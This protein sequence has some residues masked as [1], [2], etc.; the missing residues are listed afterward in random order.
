V[1][2][3]G[4]TLF[5]LTPELRWGTSLESV[6]K[7][8]SDG[9]GPALEVIGHQ[10]WRGFP[11]LSPEVER[12][13]RTQVDDL[14]LSLASLGVYTDL[15]REPGRAMSVDQAFDDLQPQLAAGRRLGFPLVRATLGMESALLRRAAAEAARLGIGLTFEVQ[16]PVSPDDPAVVEVL[17]LRESTDNPYLG[18][19]IDF[20]LTTP[21]LPASF[22]DALRRRGVPDEVIAAVHDIWA[23][24]A[25]MGPRMHAA[26]AAVQQLPQH[27]A[28][29]P[30]VGGM[31]VRTGRQ[32]PSAWVDVLPAV[33][34]AHAKFW[35]ADV[36]TVRGPHG[37]WLAALDTAGYEGAVV[38]EWGGHELV[39]RHE[40][41]AIAVTRAHLDLLRQITAAAPH[42][43][44]LGS[45]S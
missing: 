41:D 29:E 40:V 19:T 16:G 34:H 35:D 25:P 23:Q 15:F 33:M 2:T 28:I 18:L 43:S 36:E 7:A 32:D 4:T 22:D 13:F 42:S 24:E 21:E 44:S 38:S 12:G 31:F 20:S 26:L 5:S 3:L 1:V 11:Q 17:E 37:A 27:E 30:I 39:D 14:G 9:C 6:L 10:A 8:V 45:H